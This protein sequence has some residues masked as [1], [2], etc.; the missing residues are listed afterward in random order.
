MIVSGAFKSCMRVIYV[1]VHLCRVTASSGD[2]IVKI[3]YLHWLIFHFGVNKNFLS[4]GLE[5]CYSLLF[6][7]YLYTS[8]LHCQLFDCINGTPS[9]LELWACMSWHLCCEQKERSSKCNPCQPVCC[10]WLGNYL[11]NSL[12]LQIFEEEISISFSG[13]IIRRIYDLSYHLYRLFLIDCW[14][15]VLKLDYNWNS[16]TAAW[17]TKI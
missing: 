8:C 17:W 10:G 2:G 1:F 9:A 4:F 15:I 3:E 14:N 13:A 7:Q 16:Y 11:A 12:S 5:T 6:S